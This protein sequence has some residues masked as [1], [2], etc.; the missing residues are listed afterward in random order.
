MVEIPIEKNSK[1]SQTVQWN[2]DVNVDHV[3]C[4]IFLPEN[5]NVANIVLFKGQKISKC[6]THSVN[7]HRNE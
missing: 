3:N 5:I 6:T 2:G 1:Q 7:Y 4:S